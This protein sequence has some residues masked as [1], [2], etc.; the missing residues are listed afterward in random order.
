MRIFIVGSILVHSA[1]FVAAGI[2][3][4]PKAPLITDEWA[5]D[6]DIVTD[7]NIAGLP[8]PNLS[9]AKVAP[10]V[11]AAEQLLPQLPK[12]M[13][14][15]VAAP[16]EE[17]AP[18]EKAPE[19]PKTHPVL[20]EKAPDKAAPPEAPKNAPE[21]PPKEAPKAVPPPE[22]PPKEALKE[23][24]KEVPNDPDKQTIDAK[25]LAKRKAIE[26]LQKAGQTAKDTQ[27]PKSDSKLDEIIANANK[28]G[29]IPSAGQGSGDFKGY[30]GVLIKLVRQR[31]HLPDVYN[32]GETK[33]EAIFVMTLSEKGDLVQLDL[34]KSSGDNVYDVLTKEAIKT[35][36]PFPPPPKDLVGV[37]IPVRFTP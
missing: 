17:S 29:G 7:V 32:F 6:A 5:M 35:A 12:H 16:K 2:K 20:E 26:A 31:Y 4:P 15:E 18:A 25:E 22:T 3:F 9:Q 10:D 19:P 34:T 8:P 11:K 1:V 37:E 14:P 13:A 28:V 23:A 36:A 33:V 24:P 30:I 21:P 27:A